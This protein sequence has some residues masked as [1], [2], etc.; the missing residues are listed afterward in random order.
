MTMKIVLRLCLIIA[1]M[2]SFYSCVHEEI[3]SASN[4]ASKEYINKS[5]WKEDET[6]I[7]NVMKVYSEN[8]SKIKKGSGT[9]FWSYATTINTFNESFVAVPVVENS[10]VVAVMKVPRI[11]DKIYF[12][13]TDIQDDIAFFQ[14]LIFAKYKRAVNIIVPDETARVKCTTQTIGIWMPDNQNNPD[15]IGHWEY[16]SITKCEYSF[17][18]DVDC[19]EFGGDCEGGGYDYPGGG[20]EDPEQQE[21][22]DP[23][24]KIKSMVSKPQIKDSL[25]SLKLHAQTGSKKERGFLELKSGTIQA[26]STNTDNTMFFG[27]GPNSLGTVHTHQP[28]TVGI[29]APQDIMTFL[30]I[31]RQQDSSALGNAYSGTVSSTGTYFINFTG[32][33]SDLPPAMTDSQEASYVNNLV[34]DYSD[35]HRLLLK[36]EGK[37]SGQNLS[38]VGLQKLFNYLLNTMGLSGKITLVR[39]EDGNTSTIQYDSNGIPTP[40]PC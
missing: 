13:Y 5:L 14:N 29:L 24:A 40:N 36:G 22:D 38:N 21:P 4:P 23:C 32:S 9:P 37:K 3:Y 26:G 1:V 35:F 27:I 16:K 2:L 25:N 7:K 39:E 33:A 17:E 11:K 18:D 6:Y 10:R 15:G 19:S 30:H 12:I 20:N 34:I 31:V 8:E 28:G